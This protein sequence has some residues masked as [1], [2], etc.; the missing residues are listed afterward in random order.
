MTEKSTLLAEILTRLPTNN[1]KQID[2]AT[3]RTVAS[4]IVTLVEDHIT[5]LDG[6]ASAL[7]S[8]VSTLATQ[9]ALTALTARVATLEAGGGSADTTP[10]AFSF[11]PVTNA[12][13]STVETSDPITVAGMDPGASAAVSITGGT[14]SKNSGAFTSANGTAQNGDTFAV[15]QT[16]SASNST[17]TDVVLTIGGVSGTFR[18]TTLAGTTDGTAT[19]PLTVPTTLAPPTINGSTFNVTAGSASSLDA[20]L[21]AASGADGNL[22]HEVVIPI[23]TPID[24]NF[25]LYNKHGANPTG[26]GWIVVRSSGTLPAPGVRALATDAAQM[27]KLTCTPTASGQR[28]LTTENNSHHYYLC[29]LEITANQGTAKLSGLVNFG[30]PSVDQTGIE[31]HDIVLDRCY[32]HGLTTGNYTRIGIGLHTKDTAIINNTLGP[33]L[34]ADAFTETKSLYAVNGTGGY[35]ISNNDVFAAGQSLLFGGGDP[36]TTGKVP[37]D[38]TITRNKFRKDPTWYGAGYGVKNHVEFKIGKRVLIEGNKFQYCWSEPVGGNTQNGQALSIQTKDQDG[39]ATWSET[40]NIVVRYN[41]F[42]D[43]TQLAFSLRAQSDQLWRGAA[44]C[45]NTRQPRL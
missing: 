6:R 22:N 27:A 37:S 34:D 12:P 36:L 11:P 29:G 40:S 32:V 9:A 15:K 24:G 17:E 3:L 23:G 35:L 18:V 31:P 25:T 1:K 28:V 19:L 14:Y 10:N 5:T 20:Q 26:P 30:T 2:A 16:S 43:V 4:D 38:I 7:E 41:D 45:R 33:F 42:Q 44:Q 8:S 13:L 39:T 21:L